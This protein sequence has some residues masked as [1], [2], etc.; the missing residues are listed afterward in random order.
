MRLDPRWGGTATS[1]VGTIVG[2][3]DNPA[4]TE[5]SIRYEVVFP[6]KYDHQPLS[7][8]AEQLVRVSPGAGGC[9]HVD[10]TYGR[11]DDGVKLKVT[12]APGGPNLGGDAFNIPGLPENSKEPGILRMGAFA[13]MELIAKNIDMDIK[14]IEN[15][16]KTQYGVSGVIVDIMAPREYM[17]VSRD[18][19][20]RLC[21]D[22][23]LKEITELYKDIED[24]R[25]PANG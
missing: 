2:M 7:C 23:Q 12:G 17:V 15:M 16:L 1:P 11:P 19:A 13:L 8:R 10:Y 6:H 3:Y 14:D 9:M 25:S 22:M 5:N 4:D 18:E 24:K 21:K 20:L